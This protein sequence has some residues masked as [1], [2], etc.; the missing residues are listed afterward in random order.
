MRRLSPL[1]MVVPI[2][3]FILIW[4]WIWSGH[5]DQLEA[6]I[7]PFLPKGTSYNINGFPYRLDMQTGKV[8]VQYEGESL[9]ANLSASETLISRAVRKRDLQVFSLDN[10]SLVVALK[11]VPGLQVKVKSAE[12]KASLNLQNGVIARLSADWPEPVIE[13]PLLPRPAKAEQLEVHLR[14]TPAHQQDSETDPRHPSQAE[15]IMAGKKVR[16]GAGAPF[17]FRLLMELTAANPIK[18]Y[19]G[20]QDGGTAELRE[21]QIFD[22]HGEIATV[23]A[24]IADT[25]DG[26][27][28]AGTVETV[29]P[30]SVRG[31]VSGEPAVV[32]KRLRRSITIPF[33]GGF[34]TGF[35]LDTP[36]PREAQL[37]VR[38]QEPDCP[39]LR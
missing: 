7:V 33:S 20:W 15:M 39:I 35:A 11:N 2:G 12:A 25:L 4:F 1:W 8:A 16:I 37:P 18:S 3:A 27:Q 5:R 24:T 28:I 30:G 36:N 10:P 32:R 9:S 19:A 13:T 23:K 34:P 38:G 17:G 6:D 14:E 21:L 26:L 22:S 29:C 31:A